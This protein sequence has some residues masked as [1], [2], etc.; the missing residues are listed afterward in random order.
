MDKFIAQKDETCGE[1]GCE[2]PRGDWIWND[3]W[4]DIRCDEC[5]EKDYVGETYG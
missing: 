5:Y 2:I 1:C 4:D 3:G